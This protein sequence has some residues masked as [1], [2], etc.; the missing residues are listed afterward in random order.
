MNTTKKGSKNRSLTEDRIANHKVALFIASAIS[1]AINLML[2]ILLAIDGIS[3]L[4]IMFPMLFC[5]LSVAFIVLSA[6][7]NFR[8]SY[9]LWYTIIYSLL[10]AITAVMFGLVLMGFGKESA[11][12]YFAIGLWALVSLLNLIAVISGSVRA[13]SFKRG[14]RAT[15]AI[16][17]LVV[18]IGGYVYFITSSGFFGQGSET[19]DR[20]VTF[21]YDEEEKFYVATGTLKGKG[22]VVTV[23][24]TFNGIKVGAVDCAIF[25][26]DNITTVELLCDADVQF[27]NPEQLLS[28]PDTLS[29]K[30]SKETLNEMTSTVYAMAAADDNNSEALLTFAENFAPS[31]IAED[32]VYVTF[33]YTAESVKAAEG[34]FMPMWV[35]KVGDKFSL[36]YANTLDYIKNSDISDE[37]VLADLYERDAANGGYVLS[38]IKDSKGN[39]LVGS[40]VSENMDN[41]CLNFEKIYRIEVKADNDGSYELED[42]FRYQNGESGY[43]YVTKTTAGTLLAEADPRS[44]FSLAWSYALGNSNIQTALTDLTAVVT[45][46]AEENISI[47][48]TWTLLPPTITSCATNGVNNTFT[49]GDNIAFSSSANAPD[50][51]I[52][53]RYQWFKDG[54][55]ISVSTSDFDITKVKMTEAGNYTVRVTAYSIDDAVTTLESTS[56]QTFALTVNKKELPITWLGISAGDKP[57]ERTYESSDFAVLVDFDH[58]A[59]VY[60]D[61]ISGDFSSYYTL[62]EPT[63]RTAG[64]HNV[65]IALNEDL[66][67]KYYISSENEAKIYLINQKEV[68]I[69]WNV[70]SYTY[71]SNPQAP[72]V[73]ITAGVYAA[74]ESLVSVVPTTFVPAGTHQSTASLTGELSA[75]YKIINDTEGVNTAV[76]QSFTIAPYSLSFDWNIK[77][78]QEYTSTALN[79]EATPVFIPEN[80]DLAD[81]GLS[82]T[83]ATVVGTHTIEVS[84]SNPNYEITEA[85]KSFAN[86][87]ITPAEITLTFNNN[88]QIYSG[89]GLKPVV[90]HSALKGNDTTADLG[91][92][93]TTQI[94]AGSYT[95]GSTGMIEVSLTTINDKGNTNYRIVAVDGSDDYY[96][97]TAHVAHFTKFVIA[98]KAVTVEWS[99]DNTIYNGSAQKPVPSLIAA[100]I[101]RRDD[102]PDTVIVSATV[103]GGD[104]NAVDVNG[105]DAIATL[106]GEHSANYV[107]KEA[108]VTQ[109][110]VINQA[111]LHITWAFDSTVY[112]GQSQMPAPTIVANDIFSK[113]GIK[114]DVTVDATVTGGDAINVKDGGY[115]A[116]AALHGERASNY[117]IILDNKSHAFTI[118]PAP[119]TLTFSDI[120]PTYNGKNQSPTVSVAGLQK[121]ETV[122]DVLNMTIGEKR[123][124]SDNSAIKVSIKNTNYMLVADSTDTPSY[125]ITSDKQTASFTNFKIQKLEIG[126]IWTTGETFTYNKKMQ[127]PRAGVDNNVYSND[128]DASKLALVIVGYTNAGTGYTAT[129]SLS[130]DYAGNYTLSGTTS[131]EYDISPKPVSLKWDTTKITQYK[132]A[133]QRPDVS[134]VSGAIISGDVVSVSCNAVSG[135][136]IISAVNAGDYTARAVLSGAAAGNYVIDTEYL[137]KGYNIPKR[138]V[139]LAWDYTTLTYNG[140]PQL[141]TPRITSTVY[142]TALNS[143]A[144]DISAVDRGYAG[145]YGTYTAKAALPVS[146]SANYVIDN[147]ETTDFNIEKKTVYLEWTLPSDNALIYD[148]NDKTFN[149]TCNHSSGILDKDLS[150]VEINFTKPEAKNYGSYTYTASISGNDNY[151]LDSGSTT[152]TINVAKRTLSGTWQN[153][154]ARTYTSYTIDAPTIVLSNM[155][156]GD[157]LG[158]SV[159]L[160][161]GTG[162]SAGDHRYKITITNSNYQI[163][164]SIEYCT[165]TITPAVITNITLN[166]KTYN[167]YAQTPTVSDASGIQGSDNYSTLNLS[168]SNLQTNVNDRSIT[169]TIGSGNYVF[170]GGAKTKTFD[171]KP[172]ITAK[173]ITVTLTNPTDLTYNGNSKAPEIGV[174]GLINDGTSYNL[175]ITSGNAT[176]GKA[177]NAGAYEF[178]LEFTGNNVSNYNVTGATTT[179]FTITQK[180]VTMEWSNTSL[181]YNGDYQKPS[182]AINGKVT[183]DDVYFAVTV[184]GNAQGVINADNYTATASLAGNAASNYVISG[185]N[186]QD[187]EIGKKKVSASWSDT[188]VTFDA[189]YRK[190][191]ATASGKVDGDDIYFTV[192]IDGSTEGK[193]H[194]GT[195]TATATLEG[196]AKDNYALYGSNT[197]VFKIHQKTLTV[198]WTVPSSL[199]YDGT[200]KNPTARVTGLVSGDGTTYSVAITS[201]NATDGKAINAGDYT[202]ALVLDGENKDDYTITSG[203]TKTYTITKQRVVAD[204]NVSSGVDLSFESNPDGNQM[205]PII[206]KIRKEGTSTSVGNVNDVITLTI[207]RQ[208]GTEWVTVATG[209]PSEIVCPP[210]VGTYKTEANLK[211]AYADNYDFPSGY[212]KLFTIYEDEVN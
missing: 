91:L 194:A 15:I 156:D 182:A 121:D 163:D 38:A 4:Y 48:P 196:T 152:R 166:T 178:K 148:G 93:V 50:S 127:Y 2:I 181:T 170:E 75:N 126:V 89:S 35:G 118:T 26:L 76:T 52:D 144:L 206:T 29:V 40:T 80:D 184:D 129:A 191:S 87:I 149:V 187:F 65:R 64:S 12:T 153:A 100:E 90:G 71:T 173:N 32:E 45:D 172:Y 169:V 124:V 59:E 199:I 167:G 198:S 23:P 145:N 19:S 96:V 62:T 162:K 16:L 1:F 151:V 155:I 189:T 108:N 203:A 101:C 195:Y 113:G 122:Q 66:G 95:D 31:D 123:N 63:V 164:S 55:D 39:S 200:S 131:D 104:A 128:V 193:R 13:G 84:T 97:D 49:Y 107:I 165:V 78:E 201:G 210:N 212:Y 105:Y 112:N 130:G 204:W 185:S 119:L 28:V 44:G 77:T 190:P 179:A 158:D 67:S 79:P 58:S 109:H 177:I 51:R 111:P 192:T 17:L 30:A 42:D 8:F 69:Q 116:V 18:S 209:S 136:E 147:T 150:S 133:A 53:V 160:V 102:V 207:Y 73:S 5:I 33:T 24:K 70:G 134:F 197:A 99:Y 56:E 43:R 83:T 36:D 72:S 135:E 183:G 85:N 157:S 25:A 146:F 110:F 37:A 174:S 60:D 142:D 117:Y 106:S 68:S 208:N 47:T 6:Y 175:T 168:F 139:V 161:N 57:F 94:N 3:F 141:P 34:N 137:E 176:N 81:L 154:D 74:D 92:T 125:S 86:F 11:M 103:D 171:D 9:S 82:Y 10:F 211:G 88:T 61:D 7:T 20:P 115:S 138:T 143:D 140:N 114:D 46:Q 132:N 186:T 159:V 98:P 22:K 14:T 27:R 202:F 21:V 120:T 188:S 54:Q 180:S 41:V 205:C